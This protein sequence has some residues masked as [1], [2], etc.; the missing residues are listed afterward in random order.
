MNTTP[1]H[2]LDSARDVLK[3][4]ADSILAQLPSIDQHFAAACDTILH[5]TGHTIVVGMGKSGHIASKIAATL[6]STGTPA[7]FV[8]P[9]EAGHGD[10]GMITA[11]DTVLALSYS[12]SSSEI[13][14]MMPIVQSIGVKVIA[15]TGNPTSAMAQQADIHIPI[16]IEREACPLGLAPTSSSTATLAVGDALAVALI[17]ARDFSSQDF[18]RSHPF[19]RLG[20]RLITRV[21]GVMR[22]G[23]AVPIVA[24]DA[25]VGDALFAIT[26]KGL[27]ATLIAEH[28]HLR[29]IY[30]DGDLRRTLA[31]HPNPL[32]QRIDRVMTANPHT[33]RADTL[34]AEALQSME[35]RKI[36]TLPVTDDDGR[37]LGVLHIHDLLQAGVA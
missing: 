13:L 23:D 24:P 1:Q 35:Q 16:H 27:G 21:Q 36:T 25:S 5:T 7:F 31:Q 10:L 22:S 17:T 28:N 11:R 15:I 9:A 26:G 19:G 32:E 37:I 2:W 4:E 30:T 12:G 14:T 34:A 29:G 33:T 18:A 3:T 6:A 20:R 8:H